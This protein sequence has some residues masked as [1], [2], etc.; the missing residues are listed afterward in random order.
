MTM[1][2]TAKRWKT[3]KGRVVVTHL[4]T[5]DEIIEFWRTKY[6]AI[7]AG[8]SRARRLWATNVRAG[9]QAKALGQVEADIAKRQIE[10]DA[11]VRAQLT[12]LTTATIQ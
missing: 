6:D 8:E 1:L 4:E 10:W 5:I 11:Y 2:S 3:K 12:D 7:F 9:G